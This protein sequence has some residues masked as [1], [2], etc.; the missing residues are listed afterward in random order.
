V[1][2]A[3]RFFDKLR[4]NGIEGLGRTALK[5]PNSKA[6]QRGQHRSQ[7]ISIEMLI[8][9]SCIKPVLRA[10]RSFDKLRTNGAEGLGA[11]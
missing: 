1:L 8:E 10:V 7:R 9:T 3:A 6:I 2:R 5:S 4:T 11:N